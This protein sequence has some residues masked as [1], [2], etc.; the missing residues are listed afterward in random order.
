MDLREIGWGVTD[1][2]DLVGD[3]DQ[4]P[5]VVKMVMDLWVP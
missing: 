1:W 4:W 5:A 3:T 2:I